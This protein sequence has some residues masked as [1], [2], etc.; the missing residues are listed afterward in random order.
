MQKLTKKQKNSLAGGMI[1]T[2]A[3]GAIVGYLLCKCITKRYNLLGD[4]IDT[5]V[6]VPGTKLDQVISNIEFIKNVDG[7][8]TDIIY[9]ANTDKY[10]TFKINLPP[11]DYS[12][13]IPLQVNRFYNIFPT[14]GREIK[15]EPNKSYIFFMTSEFKQV[16]DVHFWYKAFA[17][18]WEYDGSYFIMHD[19]IIDSYFNTGLPSTTVTLYH[20]E[21][22]TTY[23]T[24]TSSLKYSHIYDKPGYYHTYLISRMRLPIGHYDITVHNTNGCFKDKVIKSY[25]Y[26]PYSGFVH[27]PKGMNKLDWAFDENPYLLDTFKA[28]DNSICN[29]A[30]RND[31]ECIE[32]GFTPGMLS[33][34]KYQSEPIEKCKSCYEYARVNM[35]MSDRG[36]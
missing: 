5:S 7:K 22:D 18:H 3:G 23:K 36:L 4:V 17:K 11:G 29:K 24:G 8:H 12:V 33:C 21:S 30:I 20:Y 1:A 32:K 15:I 19:F 35:K 9:T 34:I 6:Q 28:K 31:E 16:G 27:L 14:K 25:E 26:K 13:F 10:G 2:F